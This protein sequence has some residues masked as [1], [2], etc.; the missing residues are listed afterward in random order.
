MQDFCYESI[1][2]G[3][4][5]SEPCTNKIKHNYDGKILLPAQIITKMVNSDVFTKK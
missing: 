3:L 4:T 2:K 5:N 1:H